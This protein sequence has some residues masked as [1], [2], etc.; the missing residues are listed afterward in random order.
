MNELLTTYLPSVLIL[1]IVN[2]TALIVLT[3]LSIS[4][5]GKLPPTAYVK[6]IDIWLIFSQ[7]VPFTEVL[8]HTF[9]DCMREEGEREVN[10]HGQA[11]NVGKSEENGRLDKLF[12]VSK[13]SPHMEKNQ[14]VVMFLNV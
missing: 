8:L 12:V 2:L 7:L 5:S 6:M 14:E 11:V 9:M 10:H 1:A 3:T 13:N 4:V